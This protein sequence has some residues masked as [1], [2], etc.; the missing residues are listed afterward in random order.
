[1]LPPVQYKA[2]FANLHVFL[3]KD[4][5]TNFGIL[6]LLIKCLKIKDIR[7]PFSFSTVGRKFGVNRFTPY[8]FPMMKKQNVG[9]Y[10]S[11]GM[12][13]IFIHKGIL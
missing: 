10:T 8:F 6:Y 1:M 5:N 11:I 13:D 12:G 7:W 3:Q 2:M 9:C 4:V